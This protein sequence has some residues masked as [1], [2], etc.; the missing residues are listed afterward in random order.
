M[1]SYGTSLLPQ[2]EKVQDC[3]QEVFVEIW[4][5]RQNLNPRVVV[6]AYLISCVRK[7][8]A[9]LHQR[10]R[11]FRDSTQ[12]DDRSNTIE[13]LLDFTVEDRLI[14]NE[15]IARQTRQLNQRLNALT[16]R[17]RETLYLRYHQGLSIEEIAE[18]LEINNQSV[19]NLLHRSLR[20][21]RRDW[22]GS[23]ALLLL[24]FVAPI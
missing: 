16:A 8:I 15:E 17:Q 5:Y 9:R 20:Q 10:D 6:K 4:L 22:T 3:V 11:I 18:V 24:L 21:L 7:R 19:S 12:L 14:A 13:F 2:K 1:I 23:T